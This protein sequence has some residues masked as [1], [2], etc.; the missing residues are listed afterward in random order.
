MTYF[1]QV[2]LNLLLTGDN[3]LKL[4]NALLMYNI[5]DR[6]ALQIKTKESILGRISESRNVW[7]VI[8]HFKIFRKIKHLLKSKFRLVYFLE[9]EFVYK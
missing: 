9:L 5:P 7:G 8:N 2:E 3:F 6:H 4:L 1:T